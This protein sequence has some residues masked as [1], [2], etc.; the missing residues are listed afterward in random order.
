MHNLGSFLRACGYHAA[1]K[2]L[3][4][5]IRRI[6]I[7]GDAKLSYKEFA[8]FIRSLPLPHGPFKHPCGSQNAK[9][10]CSPSPKHHSPMR[11]K[12]HCG[13]PVKTHCHSPVKA[14]CA[15]C[16]VSPCCCRLCKA[17]DSAP[18]HCNKTPSQHS[19]HAN[20]PLLPIP[21]ED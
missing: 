12:S 2:E 7:D 21:A 17:C 14:V 5:I 11:V 15:A 3:Q 19:S 18:C 8:D 6:D 10:C 20:R 13:S 16:Y 9:R 4:Q 1:D